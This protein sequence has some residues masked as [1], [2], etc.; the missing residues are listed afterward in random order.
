MLF[1]FQWILYGLF[2]VIGR[3]TKGSWQQAYYENPFE[4]EAYV[5]DTDPK[6]LQKRKFW[7]WTKYTRGLFSR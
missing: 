5:N 1:V 3:F 4:L 2:Y 7:A 6:Y